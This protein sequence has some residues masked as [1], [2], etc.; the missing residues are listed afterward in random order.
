MRKA[1]FALLA[2]LDFSSMAGAQG[3]NIVILHSYQYDYEWTRLEH[4]GIMS[5]FE[6]S[7]EGALIIK[8]DYLDAKRSWNPA[9]ARNAADYLRD[10]YRDY[11]ADVVVATD[12]DAFTFLGEYGDGI[13]GDAPVVFCGVNDFEESMLAG[14]EGRWTGVAE[15]IDYDSTLAALRSMFPKVDEVRVLVDDSTT[16]I[17]SRADFLS[18]I[19]RNRFPLSVTFFAASDF[20]SALAEA[21]S[22]PPT[23][24][25]IL[26]TYARDPAYSDR[27]VSDI[28]SRLTAAC[29]GPVF[30]FWDFNFG[31]GIVGGALTSG[32]SQGREAGLMALRVLR[33]ESPGSIPVTEARRTPLT[34]DW[35][36]LKRFKVD[37]RN[38]P[39]G[40]VIEFA[41]QSLY[42]R[43]PRTFL[44]IVVISIAALLVISFLTV[45]LTLVIRARSKLQKNERL[46][47][48]ALEEQ[49]SLLREVHHR[50]N[51]N[52]Q[53]ISSL[54]SLQASGAAEPR[55]REALLEISDRV[56]SMALVHERLY[57]TMN[58]SSIDFIE[59]LLLLCEAL[60]AERP[61]RSGR[62]VFRIAPGS[63]LL[64]ME[65]AV[66]LGL[67]CNELIVN[68][69]KYAF[70]DGRQG[71]ISAFLTEEPDGVGTLTLA[72][73]GVGLPPGVSFDSDQSLGFQLIHALA[74]QAGE[75]VSARPGEWGARFDIR[76]AGRAQAGCQDVAALDSRPISG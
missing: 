41:P 29:T 68:S 7:G 3:R 67:I 42:E 48:A 6:D 76:I 20:L 44:L 5:A 38:L 75:T 35:R 58:F 28:V 16:G 64:D 10:T 32:F 70:P 12:N 45:A 50:V 65:T 14:R 24:A 1:A 17:S 8:T 61:E 15:Y 13:F 46:L 51:N 74:C 43:D 26:F 9:K 25:V 19:E 71:L 52:F 55:T 37:E 18:S 39:A 2:S 49:R 62:I 72:D 60:S 4:A 21:E 54:L 73:D 66:P 47:T 36:A 53:I 57:A 27:P 59:Y 63:L 23:T 69:I 34:F 31:F 11:S 30:S 56:R 22:L 33:G 40:S